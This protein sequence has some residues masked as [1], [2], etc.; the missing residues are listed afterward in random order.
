MKKLITQ[1]LL[2][3]AAITL[4]LSCLHS[5]CPVP[6]TSYSL[7]S[8]IPQTPCFWEADVGLVLTSQFSCLMSKTPSLLQALMPQ[9]LACC[10]LGKWIWFSNICLSIVLQMM[11]D[12][13]IHARVGGN[14][15]PK[16]LL[17]L[18]LARGGSG[19]LGP[20]IPR[21]VWGWSLSNSQSLWEQTLVYFVP[22]CWLK[23]VRKK[24]KDFVG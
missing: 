23:K 15:C 10:K 19:H 1:R 8:Q 21:S 17:P 12:H 18:R 2:C 3:R 11:F 14:P 13:Q 16:G 20:L 6:P 24:K 4:P 22:F 7:H 9:H 5:P